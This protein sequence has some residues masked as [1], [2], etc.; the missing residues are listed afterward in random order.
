V[1][2]RG[3]HSTPELSATASHDWRPDNERA[4]VARCTLAASVESS[5]PFIQSTI[6]V[7]H[8]NIFLAVFI[9]VHER[10]HPPCGGAVRLT[11]L[12]RQPELPLRALW[13]K[14]KSAVLQFL[15]AM[16]FPHRP[17]H[18]RFIGFA[19]PTSNLIFFGPTQSPEMPA[20]LIERD[21]KLFA[22][23]TQ[24]PRCVS[25]HAFTVFRVL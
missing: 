4:A 18:Q 20:Q 19:P 6:M 5:G 8:A 24:R 11:T 23:V 17:G 12:R 13:R 14:W 2:R 10:F 1:P 3:W 25:E 7:W 15:P 9:A 21:F 16:L 22:A